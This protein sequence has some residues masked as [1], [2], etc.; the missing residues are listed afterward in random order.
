MLHELYP[1][2]ITIAE[3]V[4]GMPA[5]CR[6][7]S[8]GGIGFDYRLSMAVPDMWIK[9]LKEGPADQDW[10]L[11]NIC[12]TLTNRRH[13]E[14]SICYAE[15]H[16]QALV[17]DKTLAFWLMDK[18]MYTN[19]SDLSELT[20]VVQR[21]L[22]LHKLIRCVRTS[23][24]LCI[25]ADV[26]VG[27]SLTLSEEKGTSTLRASESPSIPHPSCPS[28]M[29]HPS[30]FGHPEWLDFP[31]AGN[32]DS[33][34]YARRQFN[35]PDDPLLRYR[36]LNNFDA[37]MN[38]AEEK[39]G[40]LSSPQAYIS[41][42]NE[43]SPPANPVDRELTRGQRRT[44]SSC[45]S[46]ETSSSSSTSTRRTHTPTTASGRTGQASTTSSSPR[47]TRTLEDRGGS[48]P[49]CDTLRRRWS[50]TGGVTGCRCTRLRGRCRCSPIRGLGGRSEMEICTQSVL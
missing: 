49:A 46:E 24:M 8:E 11:G 23:C 22:A 29:P 5:L 39:Y 38:A 21:G 33:Y 13:G 3:D 6:S 19:M 36:Y 12:H 48:T 32:N 10:D 2:S 9:L 37:A 31:R 25:E 20:E 34:Q 50:G 18:E 43:V 30:E 14:K 26:H 4:S 15:S 45:S 47:T 44:T 35:L 28:L 1:D 42:K 40:W 41:L 27:S 7:V 17:G 16:D